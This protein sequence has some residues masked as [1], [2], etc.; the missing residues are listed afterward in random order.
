MRRQNF[1]HLDMI[2]PVVDIIGINY[3]YTQ[4]ASI[5][6][7]LNHGQ[8]EKS[9]N[10]TQMGWEIEPEGIYQ[11]IK[12]IGDRYH[13]PMFISRERDRHEER[14]EEDQVPARPHQSG[15]SRRCGGI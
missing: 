1:D 2:Q 4:D 13:K 5:R 11:V 8:G 15:S 9:S 6:S 7:F 12:Q 10:Y 3:Y 14:A